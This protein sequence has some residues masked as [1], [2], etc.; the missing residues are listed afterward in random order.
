MHSYYSESYRMNRCEKVPDVVRNHFKQ[1]Y[2]NNNMTNVEI[3]RFLSRKYLVSFPT[4]IVPWMCDFLKIK[5]KTQ[6]E[7]ASHMRKRVPK[8]L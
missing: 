8:F 2:E 5:R 1:L 7:M 3:C 6:R 4:D